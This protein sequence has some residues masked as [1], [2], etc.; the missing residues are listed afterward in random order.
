M[1]SNPPLRR[2]LASDQYSFGLTRLPHRRLRRL[3]SRLSVALQGQHKEAQ[4]GGDQYRLR[5]GDKVLWYSPTSRASRTLARSL[6]FVRPPTCRRPSHSA[7]GPSP[8][9]RVA[10]RRRPPACNSGAAR[11]RSP[12]RSGG[13]AWRRRARAPSRL[14]AGC[15]ND[16]QAAWTTRCVNANL[17]RRPATRGEADNRHERAADSI[18]GTAGADVVSARVGADRVV[19]DRGGRTPSRAGRAPTTCERAVT[20]VFGATATGWRVSDRFQAGLSE[21][22]ALAAA[23]GG[24]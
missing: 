21:A 8:T 14:R 17:A 20:T 7:Y 13:R 22:A 1:R 3:A 10:G 12:M 11:E 16:I 18:T 6:S 24:R 4:V 2:Y 9:T 19:V 15:G 23:S 5:R